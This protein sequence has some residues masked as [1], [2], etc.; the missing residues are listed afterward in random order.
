MYKVLFAN[1][2][3]MVKGLEQA[4]TYAQR[5]SLVSF[6]VSVF[7]NNKKIISYQWGKVVG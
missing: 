7:E 4:K 5:Q 1:K 2:S 6:R 3:V